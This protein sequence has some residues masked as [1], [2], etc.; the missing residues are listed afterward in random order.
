MAAEALPQTSNAAALPNSIACVYPH[1]DSAS[2]ILKKLTT[3]IH[4]DSSAQLKR[5]FDSLGF[6]KAFY[7]SIQKVYVSG[8][9]AIITG[10]SIISDDS[11]YKKLIDRSSYP[12]PFDRSVIDNKA[13]RLNRVY[14]ENGY[15]FASI[16]T[17]LKFYAT[18]NNR[19]SLLVL[20]TID[21]NIFTRNTQPR[22]RT[23]KGTSHALLLRYVDIQDNGP[24]DIRQVESSLAKLK[25]NNIIENATYLPPLLIQDTL[26]SD[27]AA[28]ATVPFDIIDKSGLGF[29]GAVGFESTQD[30]KPSV[31][32]SASLS[33]LNMFH[34]AEALMFTYSGSDAKQ[35]F[36]IICQNHLFSTCRLE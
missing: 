31:K 36:D 10:D 23:R 20:F 8:Y 34:G 16:T 15:P 33:L 29:E 13:T 4:K 5:L 18:S 30:N 17:E 19:D 6:T 28:I 12:Y 14:A 2:A 22:F 25:M 9:R 1:D 11:L 26:T 24:F 7:D 21:K 35:L 32:G 27:T 3:G